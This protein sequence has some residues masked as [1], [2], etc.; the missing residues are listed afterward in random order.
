MKKM[1][2]IER[3]YKRDGFERR[4]FDVMEYCPESNEWQWC[5]RFDVR[6]DAEMKLNELMGV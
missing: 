6:I 2:K 4:C 3:R 5:F 1:Y